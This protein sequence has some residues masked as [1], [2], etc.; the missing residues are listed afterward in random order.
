MSH[1]LHAFSW[2]CSGYLVI[3]SRVRQILHS[4]MDS[5]REQVWKTTC[6]QKLNFALFSINNFLSC[7]A[8][9]PVRAK[10]NTEND[11]EGSK[12]FAIV[13]THSSRRLK[14][15]EQQSG[16]SEICSFCIQQPYQLLSLP[17]YITSADRWRL[18]KTKSLCFVPV[19]IIDM[20]IA[21]ESKKIM[22]EKAMQDSTERAF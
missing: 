18:C 11:K 16:W 3:A 6:A 9:F 8:K 21:S 22:E 19:I 10:N 12:T 5:Q 14:P 4:R 13:R 20:R 7:S 15:P 17:S 2:L 1:Y